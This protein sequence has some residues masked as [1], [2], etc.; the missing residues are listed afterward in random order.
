M[1]RQFK[2]FSRASSV[3]MLIQ[4]C[5]W[6]S[7]FAVDQTAIGKGALSSVE[8]SLGEVCIVPATIPGLGS[9]VV[10]PKQTDLC[11]IDF[12]TDPKIGICPKQFS[13][14]PGIEPYAI[15]DGMT[16]LEF[17]TNGCLLPEKKRPGK[18]LAKF[19]SSITCSDTASILSYYELS[20]ILGGAGMVP[21]TVF[22]TM[23]LESHREQVAKGEFGALKNSWIMFA[24]A[25]TSVRTHPELFT[26]DQKYVYG[27]LSK[28]PTDDNDYEEFEGERAN[29]ADGYR[30]FTQTR[31]YLDVISDEPV[32][33]QK[34]LAKAAQ[35]ITEMKDMSDMILMDT[36]LNQQDRFGNEAKQKFYFW[37]ED[38]KIRELA[39]KKM[40]DAEVQAKGAI[41]VKKLLMK[42]ND[43]GVSK[44]NWFKKNNVLTEV[45][46]MS[47]KT[48]QKFMSFSEAVAA[49]PVQYAN[50]FESQMVYT[51]RDWLSVSANITDSRAT[52]LANCKSGKLLL[53]LDL[54][55]YLGLNP[56]LSRACE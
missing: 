22:R 31:I 2:K 20:Q 3:L 44:T 33:V 13:S 45:R 41:L 30:A 16:Q 10:D 42:D 23:N 35:K 32:Q 19:K 52:L 55:A 14:N 47:A 39:E 28:N 46:H 6:T 43:C 1:Q 24:E 27:A 7:A 4:L 34:T 49:Q 18:K 40:S 8:K 17:E 37:I 26:H 21:P 12:Y 48:Y 25:E 11:A 51:P 36:I 50:Y 5:F 54:D 9:G 15:E 38:G 56:N 29:Y 53:D